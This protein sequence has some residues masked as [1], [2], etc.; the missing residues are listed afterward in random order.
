MDETKESH[1]F[2]PRLVS[3]LIGAFGASGM[4]VF[5]SN[6]EQAKQEPKNVKKISSTMALLAAIGSASLPD[7]FSQ[8]LQLR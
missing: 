3:H 1:N 4:P 2:I 6:M 7:L 5:N 8:R